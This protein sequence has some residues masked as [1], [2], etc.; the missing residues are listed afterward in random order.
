MAVHCK[1]FRHFGAIRTDLRYPPA[2]EHVAR[3][4]NPVQ[5]WPKMRIIYNGF[6]TRILVGP[7][8]G[9]ASSIPPRAGWPVSIR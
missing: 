9:T 6:M 7:F 2:F 1:G 5:P 8:G 3:L 4:A